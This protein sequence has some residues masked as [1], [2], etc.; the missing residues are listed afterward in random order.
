MGMADR[1]EHSSGGPVRRYPPHHHPPNPP[2]PPRKA[3]RPR[4]EEDVWKE[5]AGGGGG[6]LGRRRAHAAVGGG[7]ARSGR[8]GGFG[9]RRVVGTG[10]KAACDRDCWRPAAG[11]RRPAPAPVPIFHHPL[12]PSLPAL[13]FCRP[14]KK[15]QQRDPR[16][17]LIPKPHAPVLTYCIVVPPTLPPSPPVV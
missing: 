11:G 3:P 5:E 9:V 8:F 1:P 13:L 2:S 6:M 4:K 10:P 7:G 17:V 12:P 15:K 14:R 16:R